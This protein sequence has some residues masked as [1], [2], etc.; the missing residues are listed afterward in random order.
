VKTNFQNEEIVKRVLDNSHTI[1]IVGLSDKS[2]RA[3]YKVASYLQKH[4]YKIVPVNPQIDSV[5]GEK[6][7]PDL[8]SVPD[9]ID[10]VD[11]FRKSED[12]GPIVD[13]AIAKGTKAVWM[14]LGI[15]NEEAANRASAAGLEVLMDLCLKIEHQKFNG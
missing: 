10:I 7:Y 1:A 13:Q 6:S 15:V 8:P 3:S 5:L 14:Q 11:I 4:G 9:N 2:E 12:V